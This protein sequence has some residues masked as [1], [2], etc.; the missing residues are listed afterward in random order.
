MKNAP[1]P[2]PLRLLFGGDAM[3]GRGVNEAIRSAGPAHPLAPLW[4][5]T[6]AADLFCANLECALTAQDLRYGGPPKAFYFRADP[7]AAETLRLAGVG[8]VSLA[9][10]HA[11][12]ADF[13]GLRDTLRLLDEKGIAYAGAGE[14][15]EAASRPARLRVGGRRLGCLA[16]CDHQDDFAAG[17]DRPGIRYVDL[18]SPATPAAMAREVEALAGQVDHVVVALHWQHNWVSRVAP[19][20]RS[21]AR[22]LIEAGARILW[23]HSP[24]H[25]QGVEWMGRGVVLYAGGSLV[26]DY[27]VKP[28][29]RNDLGLLFEVVVRRRAVAR[30]RAFPLAIV[31]A[32]ARPAHGEALRWI[33]AR[34]ESMC[35]EVGSRVT[36]QGAW[37][38]V[39]PAASR[40]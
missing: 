26:D 25:F 8:L 14:N 19:S 16:Y 34:F 7:P 3:L 1:A 24:H 11:L 9:N 17:V 12:D 30:V 35:E 4:P 32:Q 38:G 6:R 39:A 20:Y 5:V 22:V 23:G 27:A 2:D 40:A 36:R 21:L 33:V 37:L 29:F 13:D 10:N 15:L 28:A 31:E 18:S